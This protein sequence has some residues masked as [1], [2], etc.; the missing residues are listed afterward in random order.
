[1]GYAN[2]EIVKF[3]EPKTFAYRANIDDL[4]NY[5]MKLLMDESLCKSMGEA[6]RHHAVENFDYNV[7]ARKMI[8]IIKERLDIE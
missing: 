6:G 5:T 4:K 7:I 8:K 3:Q 1:M 2:K